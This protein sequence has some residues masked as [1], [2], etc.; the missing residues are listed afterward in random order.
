M[1]F[2]NT[3]YRL[4]KNVNKSLMSILYLYNYKNPR[5]LATCLEIIIITFN[6]CTINNLL[7]LTMHISLL[8]AA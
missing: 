7:T 3:V 4:L 5:N 8:V 2:I 6:K 1:L